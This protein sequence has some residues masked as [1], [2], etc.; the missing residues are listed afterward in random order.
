MHQPETRRELR[1]LTNGCENCS[2]IL[3]TKGVKI[4]LIHAAGFQSVF[5]HPFTIVNNLSVLLYKQKSTG[6]IVIQATL[7]EMLLAHYYN[8]QKSRY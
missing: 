3:S 8:H 2:S 5:P 7:V 6:V 1:Q 4:F